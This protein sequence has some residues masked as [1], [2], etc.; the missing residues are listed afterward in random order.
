[1][2]CVSRG[3][4]RTSLGI[5]FVFYHSQPSFL[6]E[7]ARLSLGESLAKSRHD[8]FHADSVH[9]FGYPQLPLLSSLASSRHDGC[10]RPRSG[11]QLFT[12]CLF[13]FQ[14]LSRTPITPSGTLL[15][16]FRQIRLGAILAVA[17]FASL[18]DRHT[19]QCNHGQVR[20]LRYVFPLWRSRCACCFYIYTTYD[21]CLYMFLTLLL[22]LLLLL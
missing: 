8:D 7:L 11:V 22:L 1:M 14:G 13:V 4:T 21:A 20:C 9:D 2:G 17:S 16:E 19:S 10:P 12:R 6:G 5:I 15:V 3:A 18:S